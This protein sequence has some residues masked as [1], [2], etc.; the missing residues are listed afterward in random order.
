MSILE[1][2]HTCRSEDMLYRDSLRPKGIGEDLTEFEKLAAVADRMDAFAADMKKSW[3]MT[4]RSDCPDLADLAS[5]MRAAAVTASIAKDKLPV[6]V[7]SDGDPHLWEFIR[8]VHAIYQEAGG[9]SKYTGFDGTDSYEYSGE[10]VDILSLVLERVYPERFAKENT[11][12]VW[13]IK[14]SL[15]D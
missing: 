10:L 12:L 1:E 3:A 11:A 13:A 6:D 15:K 8:R 9:R 4:Q 7:G 2:A 14:R 5:K